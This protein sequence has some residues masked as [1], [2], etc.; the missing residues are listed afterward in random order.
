VPN[1]APTADPMIIAIKMTATW[2]KGL[3]DLK[4]KWTIKIHEQIDIP[5][6]CE[7]MKF[8]T[9]PPPNSRNVKNMAIMVLN[10]AV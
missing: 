7:I 6:H 9:N 3:A 1:R 4:R 10:T 5:I 8:L 2:I